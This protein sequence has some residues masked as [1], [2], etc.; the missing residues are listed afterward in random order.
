MPV[1][2]NDL[3]VVVDAEP[4]RDQ[5]NADRQ[6]PAQTL[7]AEDI[8]DIVERQARMLARVLAH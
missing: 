3:E 4:P 2:I 7:R 8:N 1:I 6:T 5:E